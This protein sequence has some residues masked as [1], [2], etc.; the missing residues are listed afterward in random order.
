MMYSPSLEKPQPFQGVRLTRSWKR[1]M[2]SK[3]GIRGGRGGG[4]SNS[5][6]SSSSE[7]GSGGS[8]ERAIRRMHRSFELRMMDLQERERQHGSEMEARASASRAGLVERQLLDRCRHADVL[9]P[10]PLSREGSQ[11]CT[12]WAEQPLAHPLGVDVPDV[13]VPSRGADVDQVTSRVEAGKSSD[14][15]ATWGKHISTRLS[16]RRKLS[17]RTG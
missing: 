8:G 6:A 2:T 16:R 9:G 5:A 3:Y 11:R 4:S 15:A 7:G 14:L 12:R 10:E 17:E 13:D 1:W